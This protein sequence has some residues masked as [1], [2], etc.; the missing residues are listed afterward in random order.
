MSV[1]LHQ[2]VPGTIVTAGKLVTPGGEQ[3]PAGTPGTGTGDVVGPVGAVD[4]HIP[5]FNGT[6]G[7]LLKDGK[8][9]PVGAIVG[10]TDAQELSNKTFN[11]NGCI[12][13]PSGVLISNPNIAVTSGTNFEVNSISYVIK[14]GATKDGDVFRISFNSV[15]L[16]AG[17]INRG[18]IIRINGTNVWSHLSA[19]TIQIHR[20]YII[21][22][23]RISATQIRQNLIMT[24]D[25]AA[26]AIAESAVIV[27]NF[28]IDQTLI[29][30]AYQASAGARAQ[31]TASMLEF[32][33][34]P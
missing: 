19:P 28:D 6:T 10:T 18:S 1:E 20:G 2:A 12:R 7:K 22:W 33:P 23:Y 17:A 25:D 29:V 27:C 9:A 16:D 30:S 4:S 8:V 15:Q 3:G 24:R 13:R 11:T 21:T 32:L 5:Q 31:I 34:V 26:S 14:A